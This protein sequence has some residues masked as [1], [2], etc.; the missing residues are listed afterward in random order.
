MLWAVLFRSLRRRA[1]DDAVRQRGHIIWSSHET[2]AFIVIVGQ[3]QL[4][5]CKT[6][7]S[8][9]KSADAR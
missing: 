1:A 2:I 3:L 4:P 8:A 5:A 6:I 9:V 7:L